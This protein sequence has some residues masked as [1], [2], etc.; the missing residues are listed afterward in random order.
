MILLGRSRS[1]LTSLGCAMM[2]PGGIHM[3]K[4][5]VSA[6]AAFFLLSAPSCAI[7]GELE[8]AYLAQRRGDYATALGKLRA[9]AE[10]GDAD[11]QLSLGIMFVKGQGGPPDLDIAQTW[12]KRAAENPAASRETRDDAIYNRD[13]IARKL[14]ERSRHETPPSKTQSDSRNAK[15]R[16]S[17]QRSWAY[18]QVSASRDHKAFW[19][20]AGHFSTCQLK[21][22]LMRLTPRGVSLWKAQRAIYH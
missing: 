16:W 21:P 5:C 19:L 22:S 7:S 13:F 11:A 9:L 15:L 1:F 20:P 14:S 18:L 8:E 3:S 17:R 4:W 2:G 6:I 12:F 10:R